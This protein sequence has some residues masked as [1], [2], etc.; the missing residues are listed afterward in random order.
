MLVTKCPPN[1]DGIAIV[2]GGRHLQI[3]QLGPR[4]PV[5]SAPP[6]TLYLQVMPSTVSSISLAAQARAASDMTTVTITHLIIFFITRI[7]KH[8]IR[9]SNKRQRHCIESGP[10]ATN[11]LQRKSHRSRAMK[12]VYTILRQI[13]TRANTISQNWTSPRT[14]WS[15]PT[16][17]GHDY[18]TRRSVMRR[19]C[20]VRH[21]RRW[22]C[23]GTRSRRAV[24]LVRQG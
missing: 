10:E 13:A 6:E 20:Q 14:R 1:F 18:R 16:A 4:N 21:G 9:P 24:D 15:A 12:T 7:L 22:T 2:A 8:P 11:L 5:I 17:V 23:R 3:P 19:S